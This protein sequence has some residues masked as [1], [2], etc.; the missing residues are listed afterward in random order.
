MPD[1]CCGQQCCGIPCVD[2]P[3][4]LTATVEFYDTDCG[5]CTDVVVM[6][7]QSCDA[8]VATYNAIEA[9]CEG[10]D[11]FNSIGFLELICASGGAVCGTTEDPAP[12]GSW[13][14]YDSVNTI[15]S[16]A[17]NLETACC[18]PLFLEFIADPAT[19]CIPFGMGSNSGKI[20]VT[21][22]A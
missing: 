16:Y 10:A 20:R 6:T 8:G 17:L 1:C 12:E 13:V 7:K 18:D 14:F 19:F 11:G 3:A 21:I 9:I 4:T 2:M 5:T 15:G 22:T